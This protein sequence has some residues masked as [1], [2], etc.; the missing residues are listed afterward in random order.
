MGWHDGNSERFIKSYKVGLPLKSCRKGEL[1]E[2]CLFIPSERLLGGLR[3]YNEKHH[4][5]SYNPT[6]GASSLDTS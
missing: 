1:G 5:R 3:M 4:H 6:G 2:I